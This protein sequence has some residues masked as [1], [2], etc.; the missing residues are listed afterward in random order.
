MG[1]SI[2]CVDVDCADPQGL[3]AFWEQAL[4]WRRTHDSGDEVVLEPPEDS[5]EEGVAPD[6]LF[7]RVLE[8]KMLKNRLHLDLRP[9]D[10]AVEVARLESLGA[11]RASVGQDPDVRWVVMTDPESNEFCVLPAYTETQRAMLA[12]L[13]SRARAPHID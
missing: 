8:P 7:I 9:D 4:G 5:L 11:R 12:D 2:Q 3:A 6:L 10:Q 13:R 1:L